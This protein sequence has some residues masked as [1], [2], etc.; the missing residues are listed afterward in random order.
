MLSPILLTIYIV[1][2]LERLNLSGIGCHV[3]RTYAGAFGYADDVYG[4]PGCMV[5]D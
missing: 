5:I 4:K 2:L 3:G 1:N